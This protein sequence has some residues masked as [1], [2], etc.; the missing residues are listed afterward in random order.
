MIGPVKPGGVASHA[1]TADPL[2]GSIETPPNDWLRKV[3]CIVS[4]KVVLSERFFTGNKAVDDPSFD[5]IPGGEARTWDGASEN[6]LANSRGDKGRYKGIE[7]IVLKVVTHVCGRF[8]KKKS[9]T[10]EPAIATRTVRNGVSQLRRAMRKR[11]WKMVNAWLRGLRLRPFVKCNGGGTIGREGVGVEESIDFST[12]S[13]R[14]SSCMRSR[15]ISSMDVPSTEYEVMEYPSR[16]SS[17]VCKTL[18]TTSG[19]FSLR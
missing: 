5:M 4:T 6:T 8:D 16:S 14:G 1:T 10:H 15:K 12:I 7:G 13:D 17:T 2:C 3:C 18:C 11:L 19:S 9:G